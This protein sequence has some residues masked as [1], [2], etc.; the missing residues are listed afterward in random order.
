MDIR[1]SPQIP[2]PRNG[3][4][5]TNQ[6][7][8]ALPQAEWQ[9]LQRHANYRVLPVGQ[10]LVQPGEPVSSVYFPDSGV[11]SA[12][13]N[14]TTGHQVEVAAFGP[15]GLVGAAAILGV[16][17]S[18]YW[19]LIQ[20]DSAGYQVPAEAFRQAFEESSALR[21]LV[22]AHVGRMLVEMAR[23]AACNRFHSSH[24]RLARWLLV[25]ADKAGRRSLQ[26]THE[27]IAQMVG[28]P[29]HAV[30]AALNEL[31]ATGAI[32]GARGVIEIVD[33]ENL[34]REACECYKPAVT[35]PPARDTAEAEVQ[36]CTDITA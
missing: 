36:N 9:A 12:V 20:V 22:L 25:T 4:A 31:R 24:Q 26:L 6:I 15:D 23:S 21:R 13:S 17:H 5:P 35:P 29:R 16:P 11:V 1:E 30:T 28:G 10:T 32:N 3:D 34:V 8:A 33:H 19:L 14:L 27:S 18:A 2:N 7:L